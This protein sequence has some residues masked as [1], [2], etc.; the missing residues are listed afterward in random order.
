MNF[1]VEHLELD[2]LRAL[3]S[4]RLVDLVKYLNEKSNFYQNQF[5]DL[6]I[7]PES[8]HSIEDI[9]KLPIT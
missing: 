5:K 3:Q 2:E 4:R 1:P 8:V 6:E 7:S 9:T